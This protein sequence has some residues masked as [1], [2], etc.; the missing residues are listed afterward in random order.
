K[1]ESDVGS[2]SMRIEPTTPRAGR[3]SAPTAVLTRCL[4]FASRYRSKRSGGSMMCMSLS[5]NR[6][7]SFMRVASS[8]PLL[9]SLGS[10]FGD[11][12]DPVLWDPLGSR[13]VGS[14]H[15]PTR[16]DERGKAPAGSPP[17]VRMWGPRGPSHLQ[18]G[19]HDARTQ[20]AC[21]DSRITALA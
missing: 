19:I 16:D 18:E 9:G 8:D 4:N 3:P 17:R 10:A 11:P 2:P 12:W 5:T 13:L 6:R 7:P 21:A 20:D 1:S 14:R 15:H